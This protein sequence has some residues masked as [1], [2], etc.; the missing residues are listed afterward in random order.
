[1][2]PLARFPPVFLIVLLVTPL[3]F[4]VLVRRPPRRAAPRPIP[5][6]QRLQRGIA[7]E[8]LATR[9]CGDRR[10]RRDALKLLTTLYRS[11]ATPNAVAY[12]SAISAYGNRFQWIA[13]G[14]PSSHGR[15]VAIPGAVADTRT[16]C[17]Q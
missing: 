5:V 10:K 8:R 7:S 6:G 1:M 9:A 16:Q 11:A 13:P 2:G 17:L 12:D 3:L 15:C 4:V 14:A